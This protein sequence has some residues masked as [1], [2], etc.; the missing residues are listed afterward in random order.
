MLSCSSD[1]DKE[2]TYEFYI[3]N[4]ENIPCYEE[5]IRKDLEGQ[6][7]KSIESSIKFLTTPIEQT[8]TKDQ[9][10]K[11]N[12]DMQAYADRVTAGTDCYIERAYRKVK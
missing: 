12:K 3:V 7:E 10:K 8:G 5:A 9:A 1:D 4:T 6:S 2:Y 11:A